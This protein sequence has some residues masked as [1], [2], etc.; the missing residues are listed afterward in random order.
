VYLR[1]HALNIP[2]AQITQLLL[3][4]PPEKASVFNQQ[5]RE[6]LATRIR[7]FGSSDIKMK[8][9]V[10]TPTVGC[11]AMV[12]G[13]F[14]MYSYFTPDDSLP[15]WDRFPF[16]LM[17]KRHSN[18]HFYGINFHYL[19]YKLRAMLFDALLMEAQPSGLPP[20]RYMRVIVRARV[21]QALGRFRPVIAARKMY[22]YDRVRS[23][24]IHIPPQ[25]WPVALYLPMA[26]WQ[27]ASEAQ[28]WG[29]SLRKV[30]SG[31]G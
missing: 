18:D 10:N 29:D 21:L 19:N 1:E 31:K 30:G 13:G 15:Y 2:V 17:L 14:Y 3:N 12:P 16:I 4:N 25:D 22:R 8:H 24:C 27:K 26:K 9:I 20:H 6:W 5:A 11:Q 28:V 23:L 7:Q